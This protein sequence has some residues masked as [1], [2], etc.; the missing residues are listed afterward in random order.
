MQDVI[1]MIDDQICS[2][3]QALVK[4]RK[5]RRV[6]ECLQSYF[7]RWRPDPVA[8]ETSEHLMRRLVSRGILPDSLSRHD[9]LRRGRPRSVDI[10]ADG[11]VVGTIIYEYNKEVTDGHSGD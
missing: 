2:N 6:A 10:L 8:R 9:V 4:L 3:E 11:V 5:A 7:G 1:D